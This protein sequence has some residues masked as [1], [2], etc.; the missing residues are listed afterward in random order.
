MASV[1]IELHPIAALVAQK[2]ADEDLSLRETAMAL[3]VSQG[4]VFNW[5]RGT[6]PRV[7]TELLRHLSTFLGLEPTEMLDRLG[8]L[9]L[10]EDSGP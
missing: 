10:S 3:G 4:S 5:M 6:T 9:T 7:E 1:T 8:W 2:M